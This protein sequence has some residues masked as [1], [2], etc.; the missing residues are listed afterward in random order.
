MAQIDPHHRIILRDRLAGE[1]TVLANERTFLAVI[2]TALSLAGLG[3]A[4]LKL[5]DHLAWFILGWALMAFGV[6]VLA[7]GVVNYI[8]TRRLVAQE[9]EVALKEMG[10][11]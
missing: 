7:V 6:L 5:M 2:R 9:A 4:M 11:T 1:R 8:R 3:V 10:I